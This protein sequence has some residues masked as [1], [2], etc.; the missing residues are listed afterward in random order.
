MAPY[1]RIEV[2]EYETEEGHCPFADWF[3]ELDGRTAARVRAVI[4]RMETGNFSEVKPV[5]EGVA[6]RRIDFGPGY[7]LD[8]GQDG[9][10]LVIL[11]MGGTKKRQHRDIDRAKMY[12]NDYK[13]RKIKKP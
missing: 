9:A 8:F 10:C 13:R 12:W 3:S 2:V 5:G 1:D 11:L 6:E 7:R 4:A